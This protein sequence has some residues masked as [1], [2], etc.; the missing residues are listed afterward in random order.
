MNGKTFTTKTLRHKGFTKCFQLA[1]PCFYDMKRKLLCEALVLSGALWLI[2]ALAFT[3]SINVFDVTK[4][5][6]V[7]DGMTMNTKTIQ[8]AVQACAEKGG[9]VFFPAGQYL[10][11]SI[12]LESNVEIYVERGATILGSTNL[13]DYKEFVPKLK[14]YND[15]FLRHSLFYAEGKENISIRGEGTIDGQGAAFKVTTTT[16]PDRYRNRPYVIRFVECK[17][18]TIENVTLQK[19]AM[20]MQQYLAC[21]NLIVRGIRVFNHSN[22][23]NDMIDIDG[24]KNVVMADCIGD[25][26]DDAITL[27]STSP[28]VTENVTITNCI[29]SSHCNAIKT[30]TESTGGFRNVSISNIIVKPSQADSVITGKRNGI[31]GITLATVDGGILD[32]ITISNIRIDGPEV[33]MF[34]RLG[35]RARKHTENAPTPSVGT[36]RNVSIS[37][38][39]ATNVGSTGCSISGIPNHFV[40]N[41]SLSN[42]RIEFAGGGTAVDATK[43]MQGNEAEYPE[44]T[45]W[46]TLPSYGFY[47][48][49]VKGISFN[50]IELKYRAKDVRPALDVDDV[51]EMNVNGFRAQVDSSAVALIILK[52]VTDVIIHSSR[53]LSPVQTF[54]TV[55]GKSQGVALI[56]NDTRNAKKVFL[57]E[58]RRSVKAE[59]NVR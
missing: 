21:E 56:A 51:E 45:G 30:G 2:P 34:L 43:S 37:D 13:A 36:F 25:T 27:K 42:I 53:S 50:N 52:N 18:I 17:N 3:Q 22:K 10:T 41:V 5:G 23:N 8:R 31:S 55:Q 9:T 20:W 59:G 19:S 48:R 33:P 7:S 4:F 26:D 38:V 6:A 47:V 32:G 49:H 12:V 58:E 14:S 24:C 16:K 35:N 28:S 44:A 11:G 57:S 15:L 39:I 1:L 54:V 40:E 29:V 46:G